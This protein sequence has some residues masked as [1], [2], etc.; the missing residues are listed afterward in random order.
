MAKE[1]PFAGLGIFSILPFAIVGGF[2]LSS[3]EASQVCDENASQTDQQLYRCNQIAS[4]EVAWSVAPRVH[5]VVGTLS[6][7]NTLDY[8][9]KSFSAS[10]TLMHRCPEN[11]LRPTE[12]VSVCGFRFSCYISSAILEGLKIQTDVKLWSTLVPLPVELNA[13]RPHLHPFGTLTT[14]RLLEPPA[15]LKSHGRIELVSYRTKE[16]TANFVAVP[17]W[18]VP[19]DA[20]GY[21]WPFVITWQNATIEAPGSAARNFSGAHF[22]TEQPPT[23]GEVLWHAMIM[24]ADAVQV[25]YGGLAYV[26]S[27]TWRCLRLLTASAIEAAVTSVQALLGA[28]S[29][30]FRWLSEVLETVHKTHRQW[31]YFVSGA[32]IAIVSILVVCTMVTL[33]QVRT[34]MTAEILAVVKQKEVE[35]HRLQQDLTR[36]NMASQSDGQGLPDLKNDLTRMERE[37][38]SLMQKSTDLFF[39]KTCLEGQ[40]EALQSRLGTLLANQTE[41]KDLEKQLLQEKS[42]KE[43]LAKLLDSQ[44]HVDGETWQFQGDS[45][46]WVSFPEAANKML[47]S[48][49]KDGHETCNI[50]IDGKNYGVDFKKFSQKNWRT[51]KE[52]SIRCST[53]L[54]LYWKMSDAI[55]AR[56][57]DRGGTNWQVFYEVKDTCLFLKLMQV[58]NSSICRHDG[59]CCS[60]FHGSSTFEVIQAYQIKNPHL[61]RR[62]QRFARSIRDKHKQQGICPECIR[63]PVSNAL[64]EFAREIDVDLNGNERLL[65]H[66]TKDFEVAK[67]IAT[68]GFDNRVANEATCL[69]GA[70][71]YFAAQTCKS[72]QYAMRDGTRKKAS[73]EVPGTIL[74]ARVAIGDPF[75]TPSYCKNESRPPM[76]NGVRADSIIARPGIP[77]GQPGA[78]QSHLEVVTFDPAQAYPE[79]ILRFVER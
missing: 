39:E 35:I 17:P 22:Q 47:L 76:K 38:A 15:E 70:G 63:P 43:S 74:I 46:E 54:P 29:S 55:A 27:G 24:T 5:Q 33:N 52:R 40:V 9:S 77:N 31:P 65:L 44:P 1:K 25:T 18:Q 57:L 50:V 21:F 4:F 32:V 41:I 28:A 78:V 20:G 73:R 64:T 19:M 59:T 26:V 45:G 30:W 36:R 67:T 34:F 12:S 14:K 7:V 60:C 8:L 11:Q 3:A 6:V 62:Y 53:G 58:L 75:Y 23:T 79:F 68:E 71:T 72:A 51:G 42:E 69:Y 10:E 13:S 37:N 49:F 16:L 61:W 2:I 48:K 66:G 56:L